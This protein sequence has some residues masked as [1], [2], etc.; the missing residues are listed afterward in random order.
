M[1]ILHSIMTQASYSGPV[2]SNNDLLLKAVVAG[3]H[4]EVA[5]LILLPDVN[6]AIHNNHP[7]R[8]AV[9][10]NHPHVI[11]VLLAPQKNYRFPN[12]IPDPSHDNNEFVTA[13]VEHY[14]SESLAALI[15]DSRVNPSLP[16]NEPL[17]TAVNKN[18]TEAITLLLD[19]SHVLLSLTPLTLPLLQIRY[20]SHEIRE[21]FLAN[22]HTRRI[23]MADTETYGFIV[24]ST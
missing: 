19:N 4:K 16:N 24:H 5:K 3:N 9:A 23:M 11:D 10:Y 20:T 1:F 13:A 6:P 15:T 7:L 2:L 12:T 18:N 21:L 14:L 22:P 17:R 8:L